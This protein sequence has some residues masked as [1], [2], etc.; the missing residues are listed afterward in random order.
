[1]IALAPVSEHWLNVHWPPP[2]AACYVHMFALAGCGT[3]CKWLIPFAA[4]SGKGLAFL[5]IG[6]TLCL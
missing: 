5:W 6:K 4:A 3:K 2:N 1:M